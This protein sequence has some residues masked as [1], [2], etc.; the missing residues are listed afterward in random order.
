MATHMHSVPAH[1]DESSLSLDSKLV[2]VT[3]SLRPPQNLSSKTNPKNLMDGLLPNDLH[4][5]P[6]AESEG[7]PT[8][9]EVWTNNKSPR[10]GGF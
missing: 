4:P 3:S 1:I 6:S 9:L 7:R 8:L 2:L 10:I 5:S